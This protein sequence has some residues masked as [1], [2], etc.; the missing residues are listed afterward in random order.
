MDYS[1]RGIIKKQRQIKTAGKKLSSKLRVSVIRIS[2]ILVMFVCIVGAFTVYGA[3]KSIIDNAPDLTSVDINPEGYTSYI[4]YR[5]GSISQTLI[6]QEA[7]RVYV[8]IDKVPMHVRN[9]FIA[10]EDERFYDHHGIDVRGIFR[11]VVSVM[12]TRKLNF[13]ASTI[14]QQVLKNRVFAG[15]KEANN[16]DK[17]VRKIQEQFLAVKLENERS[18]DEILEAY[19]NEI[20]LG[21]RSFGIEVAAQNY[22][23]KG[24]EDLTLSE[25]AVIAPIAWSPTLLNPVVHPE[26]NAARRLS[27]LENMLM[28]GFCTQ[29]EY[30]AAL[31][32]DVYGRINSVNNQKPEASYY[33]YYV[34]TVINKVM[35]DLQSQL[36]YT[37]AEA[38]EQIYRG[39][40]KIYTAQ[41]RQVQDIM[42]KYYTD[43][44]YFPAVGKG[45]Y[46]EFSQSYAISVYD[47][48]GVPTHYH[49]ADFVKYF[50]NWS[51]KDG[52]Y[53]H[54]KGKG[55]N[56]ISQYT[57]DIDD[58][59]AKLD[60]YRSFVDPTRENYVESNCTFTLQPQS[61]MV[62]ID[63]ANGE[64][65]GIY[66]GRGEKIVNRSL[67]RA[68]DSLRQVGSTF[69]V[70]A[71]FLPALD[72]TGLTLASVADD[73]E[74]TYPNSIETVKNWWGSEYEGLSPIR[75]AIYHSM[76]IVACRIM[77]VVTPQ[78]SFEYLKSLGFTTLVDHMTMEDGRVFTDINVSMA[79]GGLTNGVTNVEVTAAYAT[80]ANKGIYNKPVFYT[81]VVDHDGK[82]LLMNEV[83]GNQVIKSSTAWL[84]TNAMEDTVTKGTG[85]RLAFKN[86]KMPVAG[87]T[88][89]ASDDRDLWFV[90]YTPYYTCGVW[91]GFDNN[92]VQD[93][94]NYQRDLWR[95]IMEDLHIAKEKAAAKFDMPDSIVTARVCAKCGN[96]ELPGVCENAPIHGN[97]SNVVTEYFAKGTVP[98]VKCT[99]HVKAYRCTLSGKLAGP[100]CPTE[101]IEEYIYLKKIEAP[102]GKPT[103]DTPY[104]YPTGEDAT[105]DIHGGWT[106]ETDWG[107]D[108]DSGWEQPDY[109]MPDT[110]PVIS[111]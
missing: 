76:N 91:S 106:P 24:V 93:D 95:N 45:S 11:A 100:Y 105:C 58:M 110:D 50:E 86:L 34:D 47:A 82:V 52:K 66:G 14:T 53:Y 37:E 75:R 22:F 109:V 65:V 67:N 88:G 54:E 42:D 81:K 49:Y 99:C 1:R 3:V 68:S 31:A 102:D 61:S 29:A 4:Y 41:D 90:G 5:D 56:G 87:K 111:D 77:E 57:L 78:V 71:S 101:Y 18:K 17:I 84:L 36:G 38:S 72:S 6:G 60:E 2:V 16:Y 35:A 83:A 59:K 74:Y 9:A 79:L 43:E 28:L 55:K 80:I 15:G 103:W 97:T 89:T 62:I 32:D 94:H 7:N 40:L 21:N 108:W 27:C 25:A 10:L 8:T 12:E 30:D 26:D 51:D 63:Q 23:G 48:E 64:V 39:G 92:F 98:T 20:N 44:Q 69:K 73:S 104:I 107:Y 13:G 19:I 70:L 85:T 33:S 46:Y 96:L